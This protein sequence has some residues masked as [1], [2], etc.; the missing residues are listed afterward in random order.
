[1]YMLIELPYTFFFTKSLI[2]LYIIIEG[3]VE[4]RALAVVFPLYKFNGLNS[5]DRTTKKRVSTRD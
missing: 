2:G 5:Q 1:M 3:T 4:N